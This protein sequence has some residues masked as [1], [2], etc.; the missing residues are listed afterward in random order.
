MADTMREQV[1]AGPLANVSVAYRN[2][3]MVADRGFPIIDG[4]GFKAKVARYKKADWFRNDAAVRGPGGEAPRGTFK[5]DWI[6]IATLEYAFASEVT[7]E[8][9]DAV[10][11]VGGPPMQPAQDAIEYAPAKI[12]LAK[13]V[14]VASLIKTAL[15]SGLSAGG[16]DAEGLWAA[17][18]GNTFLADIKAGAE[19][20]RA[21]TGMSPNV[22][23]ID[24]GTYDS[25]KDEDSILE[26]LSI[27]QDQDRHRPA[28]RLPHRGRGGD[29]GQDG[30]QHRKGDEDRRRVHRLE[31][32]GGQRGQGHGLPLRAAAKGRPE[33]A[34]GGRPG[35][36]EV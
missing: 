3:D 32:L 7:D 20:I 21:R 25:L 24:K 15:W 31:R 2:R 19:Y 18:A 35:A 10:K 30:H 33:D 23:L 22:L 13:E 27:T 6:D 26:R 28:H 4:G 34:L 29:R 12:D 5:W 8:D 11:M 1:V 9:R 36:Q 14:R 17:G 16:E